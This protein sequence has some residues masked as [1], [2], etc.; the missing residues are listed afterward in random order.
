MGKYIPLARAAGVDWEV[1]QTLSDEELEARLY[2]PAVPRASHQLEPDYARPPGTQAPG[3]HADAAVGGVPIGKRWPT[4]TQLLHQVPRVRAGPAALDAP[5]PHRRREA[6]RRLR[7]RH[8]AII[9]AATGE[10]TRAQIFVAVLGASNYTYAGATARQTTA[11]WIGA[12]VR[13]LEFFG[14]VPR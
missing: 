12:H 14:G 1:A 6:V 10:I 9:D 8:R 3:R 4:S 11:D 5:D 2:R 7:R 13:A